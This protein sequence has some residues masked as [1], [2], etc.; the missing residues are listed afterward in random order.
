MEGALSKKTR[1]GERRAAKQ[2]RADCH[3]HC[4]IQLRKTMGFLTFDS[5]VPHASQLIDPFS[6]RAAS[7]ANGG[8]S[9]WTVT[10]ETQMLQ[11]SGCRC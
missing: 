5:A 1:E 4:T 6:W 9:R 10:L 11:D 2:Q 7:E 3:A 8:E